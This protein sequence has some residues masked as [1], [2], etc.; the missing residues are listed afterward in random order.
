MKEIV[1]GPITKFMD[2]GNA[3]K[4]SIEQAYAT[5]FIDKTTIPDENGDMIQ[6]IVDNSKMYSRDVASYVQGIMEAAFTRY[7]NL[8]SEGKEKS[9]KEI[10]E[11]YVGMIEAI[12]IDAFRRGASGDTL[13]AHKSSLKGDI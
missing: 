8:K 1:S 6:Y 2:F 3:S 13:I 9:F 11:E 7:E 5:K 12:I 10:S 4:E